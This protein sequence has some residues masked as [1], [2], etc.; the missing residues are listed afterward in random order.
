LCII[1]LEKRYTA[2]GMVVLG[3]CLSASYFYEQP[4]KKS[5]SFS[6]LGESKV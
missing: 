3:L 2:I 4:S 5:D 1:F 6:A